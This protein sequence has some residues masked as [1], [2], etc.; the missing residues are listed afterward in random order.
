MGGWSRDVGGGR[1]RGMIR[2]KTKQKGKTDKECQALKTGM[3][4]L[5]VSHLA[6]SPPHHLPPASPSPAALSNSTN[7]LRMYGCSSNK[8]HSALGAK[9]VGLR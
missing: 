4:Q 2:K 1:Q 7:L 3:L 6:T 9:D 5:Y 8:T